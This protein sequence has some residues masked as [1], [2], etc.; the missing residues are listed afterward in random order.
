LKPYF[1]Q[2][3]KRQSIPFDDF[4]K[5][6]YEIPFGLMPRLDYLKSM[7]Q[8]LSSESHDDK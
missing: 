8:M 2:E 4:V 3:I 1:D 6:G 7:V 5:K